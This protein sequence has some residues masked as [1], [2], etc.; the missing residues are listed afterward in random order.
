MSEQVRTTAGSYDPQTWDTT[1]A[2][3][4]EWKGYAV[5]V[6]LFLYAAAVTYNISA[7]PP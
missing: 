6:F 1:Y 5:L 2:G 4:E 3:G 7:T